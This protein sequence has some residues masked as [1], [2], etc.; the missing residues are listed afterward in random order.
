MLSHTWENLHITITQF[1][2]EISRVF[3][4]YNQGEQDSSKVLCKQV[5]WELVELDFASPGFQLCIHYL[6]FWFHQKNNSALWEFK[7][8]TYWHWIVP[9]VHPHP[10]YTPTWAEENQAIGF[11]SVWIH[12]TWLSSRHCEVEFLLVYVT[13]K[14]WIL[15]M[16]TFRKKDKHVHGGNIDLGVSWLEFSTLLWPFLTIETGQ[17]PLLLSALVSAQG[18][19]KYISTVIR[20]GPKRKFINLRNLFQTVLETG[21]SKNRHQEV[22][23]SGKGCF[24]TLQW[25]TGIAS[26]RRKEHCIFTWQRDRVKR[27]QR[28]LI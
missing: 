13:V 10:Y 9:L 18:I 23:L 4:L 7:K 5:T 20:E 8:I 27:T 3:S 12:S 6:G 28:H 14:R 15:E 19:L 25:Y 22:Q 2:H 24:L 16:K 26:P 11:F 17:V 1:G 21:N